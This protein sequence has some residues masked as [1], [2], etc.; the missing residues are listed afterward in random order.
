MTDQ[1]YNVYRNG[2][3][4]GK[5]DLTNGQCLASG[6]SQ[7]EPAKARTA[8]PAATKAEPQAEMTLSTA[9]QHF[10]FGAGQAAGAAGCTN[11]PSEICKADALPIKP[12]FISSNQII[13]LSEL[14]AGKTA[15]WEYE[16]QP[17]V[18]NC[19]GS[20][21]HIE[22]S[23]MYNGEVHTFSPDENGELVI[24]LLTNE[25]LTSELRAWVSSYYNPNTEEVISLTYAEASADDLIWP[26]YP[27]TYVD[28][29]ST[30]E[31]TW[32]YPKILQKP[33]TDPVP[34]EIYVGDEVTVSMPKEFVEFC[35][36]TGLDEDNGLTVSFIVNGEE[37]AAI[38]DSGT[39][40]AQTIYT[41]PGDQSVVI[42]VRYDDSGTIKEVTESAS[43]YVKDPDSGEI[44]S[45]TIS[46]NLKYA[47]HINDVVE[48]IT[49]YSDD[50]DATFDWVVTRPGPD[51]YDQIIQYFSGPTIPAYNF[52]LEG[53]FLFKCKV[54]GDAAIVTRNVGVYPASTDAPPA[55]I[56]APFAADVGEDIAF[57]SP[58]ADESLYSYTWD[59]MDGSPLVSGASVTHSFAATGTYQVRLT[60]ALLSDPSIQTV[61]TQNVTIVPVSVAIPVLS[62]VAPPA[63]HEDTDFTLSVGSPDTAN[64]TYSWE[65][66]DGD[67]LAPG[68]SVTHAYDD[69]G[70]YTVYLTATSIAH[71]E[72]SFTSQPYN[73]Y[74]IQATVPL[75]SLS[76][77]APYSATVGE[78]VDIAVADPDTVNYDYTIDF[79]DSTD[80]DG[81]FASHP[82]TALGT[83]SI[84]ITATSV[85]DSLTVYQSQPHYISIVPTPVPSVGITA[86]FSIQVGSPVMFSVPDP[87]IGATY[88]WNFGDLTSATGISASHTY[89]TVGEFQV[90]LTG[91]DGGSLNTITHNITVVPYPMPN[92]GIEAP[93]SGQI[94]T[95][96]DFFVPDPTIGATYTW[97]FGDTSTASGTATSHTYSGLGEFQVRL[98]ADHLGTISSIT[99][100][101]T[102]VPYPV[103]NVSIE[104]PMSAPVGTSVDF[105]VPDPTG[106]AIYTW[107]FGDST[108][109][110]G[111]AVSKTFTSTGNFQVRLTG[112]N[113]GSTNSIT[114]NITIY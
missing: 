54:N 93:F 89:S 114:H 63:V 51:A 5:Y 62:I 75:P 80:F 18:H 94:G 99:H 6:T 40:Y 26:L 1:V 72:V 112:D 64:F 85:S 77:L 21:S 57:V 30:D 49:C 61:V 78:G 76:I 15:V 22:V 110:S 45:A 60:V 90:V 52:D 82:Y 81:T 8:T 103:P 36:V 95:S 2:S 58:S 9:I 108:S 109:D 46:S 65:F 38:E 71:P 79:G 29:T 73:I 48:N 7:P 111:T 101:I 23:V 32:P 17:A 3:I 19:N 88:T 55:A 24:A 27:P 107:N 68:S 106:G 53:N 28:D 91:D 25:E 34:G 102:I 35:G 97:E 4:V 37:Y 50:P 16:S 87:T 10:L 20:T 83:Y 59:F 13:Y 56:V 92:V 86:P 70:Q 42:R 41:H 69:P 96:V 104:G 39:Y 12:D 14:E 74:V 84:R 33:S 11:A 44:P 67:P 43:F 105:F 31:C 47:H 113:S 100:N 98:T 66:G